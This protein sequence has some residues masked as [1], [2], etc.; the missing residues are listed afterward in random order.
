MTNHQSTAI[1]SEGVVRPNFQ[2]VLTISDLIRWLADLE[3]GRWSWTKNSQ[4]K[5]VS[6]G[7]DT[8]S[9]CYSVRDRDRNPLTPEELMFQIGRNATHPQS[10]Q[11]GN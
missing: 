6:I 5:Y 11:E 7:I 1:Q 8:R 3:S 10:T 4:C 2:T 9:G